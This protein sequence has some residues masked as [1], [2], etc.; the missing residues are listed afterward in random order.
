[1]REA[2]IQFVDALG[3]AF[4]AFG[5]VLVDVRGRI[6]PA[7]KARANP[8]RSSAHQSANLFSRSRSQVIAALLSWPELVGGRRREI[9]LAAG[10]SLGQAHDV[11]TR[12][13]EAGYLLPAS[14][15]LTR[16]DELLDLWAAAYSTG[17]GPYLE[18]AQFHGDPSRPFTGE[19]PAYLSGETAEGADIARPA[20]LT[21][22]LDSLDPTLAIANRWSTNPD[23]VRNVFIRHKFWLSPRPAEEDPATKT[24][25]APW[26]LVYADLLA[27]GDA[28]LAEVARTWKAHRARSDQS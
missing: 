9:A 18:V 10:T 16:F 27:T 17:L 2:N 8:P 24:Q 6:E 23:R 26:P 7:D 19:R 11:L 22:Y 21:V 1:L 3:N 12:L 25:N 5:S 4:I 15:K 13:A 14:Q 28:R 20:T